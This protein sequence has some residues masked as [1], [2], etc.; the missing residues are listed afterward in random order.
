MMMGSAS[1]PSATSH[2]TG[3]SKKEQAPSRGHQWNFCT[4]SF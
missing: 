2:R 3:T 4:L 1:D